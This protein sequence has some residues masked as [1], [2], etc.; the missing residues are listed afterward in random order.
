ME[1]QLEIFGQGS[2]VTTEKKSSSVYVSS[3]D[4]NH[5]NVL[6]LINSEEFKLDENSDDVFIHIKSFKSKYPEKYGMIQIMDLKSING[7]KFIPLSKYTNF[8]PEHF[9]NGGAISRDKFALVMNEFKS[10]NLYTSYGEKVTDRKQAIAIALSES[11][12]QKKGRYM[13]VKNTENVSD[14]LKQNRQPKKTNELFEGGGKIGFKKLSK[15][16]A[17]RYEGKKVEPKYQLEY[18]KVYSKEEAKEVGDKVAGA[19]YYGQKH[20]EI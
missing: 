8:F 1:N 12:S 10:G 5:S 17:E 11:N 14:I 6:E 19:V 9:K 7:D 4:E 15:I 16:V 3:E 20:M 18:G 2:E 13:N